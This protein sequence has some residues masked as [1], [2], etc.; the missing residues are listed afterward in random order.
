MFVNLV[1]FVTQEH[2]QMMVTSAETV[3]LDISV[4]LVQ[5][6]N[7]K[8]PVLKE[9]TML[10]FVIRVQLKMMPV[11]HVKKE[12]SVVKKD[13]RVHLVHVKPGIIVVPVKRSLLI[14]PVVLVTTAAK[15]VLSP[16]LVQSENIAH[17]EL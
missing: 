15:V 1:N 17:H 6:Q 3:L 13:L 16:P 14:D 4:Q 10:L 5:D 8:I 2:Q 12:I 9:H 7:M 11:Y